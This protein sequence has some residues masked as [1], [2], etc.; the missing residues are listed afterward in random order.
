[1]MAVSGALFVSQS[2]LAQSSSL[3][4]HVHGEAE[5]TI[6]IEE[7]HVEMQ[8]V[9]P[10]ANILGFEHAPANDEQR[11]RIHEA[12]GILENAD[13]MFAFGGA[14]CESESTSVE[15]PYAD[16]SD[17]EHHHED[18]HDEHMHSSH[19]DDH[20]EHANHGDHDEHDEHHED[21]HAEHEHEHEH[22][23]HE[24]HSEVVANYVLE[25]DSDNISEINVA[26]LSEFPGIET[27]DVQWITSA[28]QGAQ[29]I[30]A[31]NPLIQLD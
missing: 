10:A 30:N 16:S 8:L 7:G 4:A 14:E 17:D 1:M 22:E 23:D 27:L 20:H 12:E 29:E 25:C 11:E 5:L 26:L 21:S 18:Q 6:A 24:T 19:A 3:E 13:A 2:V 9:S 15:M 28:G 31:T